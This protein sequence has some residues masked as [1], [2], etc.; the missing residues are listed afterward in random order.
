MK[1]IEQTIGEL[2]RQGRF[3]AALESGLLAAEQFL[4]DERV[5]KAI[6]T[7]SICGILLMNLG[8]TGGAYE[9][10]KK[11]IDLAEDHDLPLLMARAQINIGA[12]LIINREFSEAMLRIRDS[13]KIFRELGDE[14]GLSDALDAIGVVHYEQG[15][16]EES[17]NCLNKAMSIRKKHGNTRSLLLSAANLSRTLL[18]IGRP[19]DV[20]SVCSE[21]LEIAEGSDLPRS[22]ADV[23]L[24]YAEAELELG[25][26]DNAFGSLKEAEQLLSRLEGCF[27]SKAL[28]KRLLSR[29][30]AAKC[31][32]ELACDALDDFVKVKKEIRDHSTEEKLLELRIDAEIK[33]ILTEKAILV[34]SSQILE[35]TNSNLKEALAQ[36]KILSGMLPI[37]PRCKKIRNDSGYWEQIE[38]YL[39]D[40]SEAN[41]SHGLCKNCMYLLYP[42][43]SDSSR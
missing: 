5:E 41:F 9:Y 20:L 26:Y 3:A 15:Y 23:Y 16:L 18:D 1:N 24:K 43:F 42:E 4:K 33:A 8:D 29:L 10:Q 39:T 30:Y 22:K 31:M 35:E 25:E 6:G 11:A 40:H 28:H 12:V 37:C 38:K 13:E 7:Y 19:E 2:Q 14:Q 17:L 27:F 36:A 34:E 32:L 21:I